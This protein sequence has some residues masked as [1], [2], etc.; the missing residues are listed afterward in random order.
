MIVGEI[1]PCVT[2]PAVVLADSAPGALG[3]IRTPAVPVALALLI[4]TEA[5]ALKRFVNVHGDFSN[6]LRHVPEWTV[7]RNEARN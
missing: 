2:I 4:H 1:S 3:Q 7:M 5:N 6:G